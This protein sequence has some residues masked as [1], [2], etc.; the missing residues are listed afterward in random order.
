MQNWEEEGGDWDEE[1]ERWGEIT[2][3]DNAFTGWNWTETPERTRVFPTCRSGQ[4]DVHTLNSSS[5]FPDSMKP[6]LLRLHNADWCM[7]ILPHRLKHRQENTQV[8]F[9][10]RLHYADT[11]VRRRGGIFFPTPGSIF[12]VRPLRVEALCR[13]E[14]WSLLCQ[15]THW[16]SWCVC[17][18]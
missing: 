4:T 1:R 17:V 14:L 7:R 18:F 5:N 16:Q 11:E 6:E 12:H 3:P 13:D 15:I 10:P 8:S 9:S 2:Q